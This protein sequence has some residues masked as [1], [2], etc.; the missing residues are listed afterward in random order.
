MILTAI[1]FILVMLSIFVLL[2][3]MLFILVPAIIK[4][5]K[6]SEDFILSKTE[7]NF[8]KLRTHS[9]T[10]SPSARAKV[11]CKQENKNN[12]TRSPYSCK[13]IHTLY[14]RISQCTFMCIGSGDCAKV[15]PQ[16]AI[17]IAHGVAVVNNFCTGCGK[18]VAVCPVNIIKMVDAN[19]A[20]SLAPQKRYSKLPISIYSSLCNCKTI[21]DKSPAL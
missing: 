5:T 4:Q 10:I 16:G 6:I 2:F 18:C 20:S 14:N 1:I 12:T 17:D 11:M 19:S 3:F 8:Q 13:V 15:C 7:H 21:P 9:Q